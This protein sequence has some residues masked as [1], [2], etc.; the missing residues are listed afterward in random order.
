[1]LVLFD[2]IGHASS[3][4]KSSLVIIKSDYV[5]RNGIDLHALGQRRTTEG[6]T[7]RE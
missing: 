2:I 7:D 6:K 3:S 5:I 4:R 1:M